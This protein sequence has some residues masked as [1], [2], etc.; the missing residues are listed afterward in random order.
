MTAEIYRDA[1]GIPHLR[2]DG[3][4]EL[5]RAQGRV[6]ALDRAWQ[7]EVERRR[8]E[9]TSAAL[10]GP[11]S[12]AW[13]RFV[14]RARLD[15]T[16]RRCWAELADGDP[17]TADWIRAYV[18]G[19]NEGLA[20]AALPVGTPGR[21][22]PWTPLG[23]WLGIHILFAGFPAK[24]WRDQAVRHL[25]EEAVGL[26]AIDGPGT[27]GSN[28]WL[29]S[30]ERTVSGQPI[31]AGDPHR[32]IEDAGVY[33]QIHLSCPEFDVVGLAVPGVPGIAHFGHTGTVAWAITNAM[34]DYQ[35][36]YRE[37]LRRTG[38]GVEALGPDGTWA[39]AARHTETIEVAGEDPV[40]VEVIETDR[41]P[42]VIGGPEGL[43]DGTDCAVSL[44][45]PPRVTGD[46][47]FGA[48]LPLLRAR[49]VADVD[50]AFDRWTEPVNVVQAADTEGGLLH[51]VAGK[52]P[53][54]ARANRT[55][56]VPAWEPGHAWQ[57]WHEMPYGELADGV[58]VMANQRG[59]AAP[60]GVEFAPPHRA[61]RIA[62]LLGEKEQW[63][64]GDM[65][66][67]HTDT[68]LASA[69]ALLDRLAALD[70]L[71]PEAAR[72]RETLLAWDRRMDADSAPAAVYAAVRGAVVRR[73]A[74]HPAFAALT[75]PPAYPEVL[76]PWLALVP[77]IGY[78]LEHLLRA[79]ELYGIDRPEAVRAAV[80]EVAARPP[81]GVWGDTHR[82]APWRALP[83]EYDEPALSGDH[84]CVLCTSAVPGIT[85][86]AAR[87]PAARYVWDL[88]RRE[89]SLWVV[90]FGASGVPGTP[91]HRDQLP[92]WTRGELVPVV[93]DFDRLE[94]ETDV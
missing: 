1:W 53:R 35:D 50:R 64:P 42:V 29:V 52:V 66:A 2:A 17:E 8:A 12:L 3:A 6:T 86:L 19:V 48:L 75:A 39:R 57:G 45:Y 25:G 55:R 31:I 70:G 21:W 61:D 11:D 49:R 32:F 62:A 10:L 34:A 77:R 36:L 37:R 87:G 83:A 94:K 51:R 58:A 15:D 74:V 33:Q 88:D 5:A 47:G 72:L 81:G 28:G 90:P 54:R 89:H 7:L 92:L 91:H 67:I 84:D 44:R 56:L 93:T 24:L 22:E 80:E 68:H 63:A 76:L 82:L 59:P 40:E 85:D 23:I 27:S 14:R 69:A 65:P 71:S 79:E 38:A 13:D 18:D 41:G 43:D 9:G 30:G 16:A 46:L 73:L 26:F 78:A 60:L 20:G 4:R